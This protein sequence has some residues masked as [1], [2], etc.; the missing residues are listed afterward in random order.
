MVILTL[1]SR[2]EKFLVYFFLD[3]IREILN[4][5]SINVSVWGD[6][7][8]QAAFIKIIFL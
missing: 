4:D 7:V 2:N 1:C 3:F 8:S 6:L 5:K